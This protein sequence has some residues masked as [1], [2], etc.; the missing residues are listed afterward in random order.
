MTPRERVNAALSHR[1]PDRTPVDFLAT[2]EIWE[3]LAEHF[4]YEQGKLDDTQFFDPAWE[5]I[6]RDLEVDCRVVSYDQF[7]APPASAFHPGAKTEWWKVRSRSTP[8]RM[9]RQRLPDGLAYDIFGRRFREQSNASGCYEE[10]VPVLASAQ[11]L[12]DLKSHPWPDPSW[13]DFSRLGEAIGAMNS[14]VEKHVRYRIG[15]VFEVAWQLR[16]MENFFMDLALQ[17]E[18]VHYMLD[19]LTDIY[20]ENT[21]AALDAAGELIDMVYFYDDIAGNDSLLISADMWEEFIRPCHQRIID[22]AKA[23]GK[24]VMYHSDG[25]L[26]SVMDRLVDM[27]I[28][29]LNPIQPNTKD[30]E[31]ASLKADYGKRLSFH[32]GIDIIGTLPKGTPDEVRAEV[33]KRVE[34]MGADGGYVLASSHHIQAD[35]PIANVLA[36]YEM[37]LR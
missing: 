15:A 34:T 13:W 32:G 18:M 26:R 7:C 37:G 20:V 28:D 9:W 10:N 11:S 3:R 16:G 25:A 8:A 31:P 27:G 17:P 23:K 4:A 5:R 30:M 6:L 21:R 14:G 2:P 35:T 22:L 1:K 33:R 29:V 24:K 19:R 36:M 12:G